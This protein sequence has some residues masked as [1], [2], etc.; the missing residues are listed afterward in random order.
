MTDPETSCDQQHKTTIPAASWYSHL[1]IFI[2]DLYGFED[3]SFYVLITGSAQQT[4]LSVFNNS[5]IQCEIV[6]RLVVVERRGERREEDV[7]Y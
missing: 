3:S 1:T 6:C 4:R 5:R 7:N 2:I